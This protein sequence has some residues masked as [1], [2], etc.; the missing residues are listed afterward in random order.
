MKESPEWPLHLIPSVIEFNN[1]Q[2]K[3][4]EILS[5]RL[6]YRDYLVSTNI[7]DLPEPD[8]RKRA[9]T[10]RQVEEDIDII[11]G[12]IITTRSLLDLAYKSV[13]FDVEKLRELEELQRENFYLTV[14]LNATGIEVRRL[15]NIL[16]YRYNDYDY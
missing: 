11:S 4:E 9:V 15:R 16:N 3:I 13:S 1:L 2:L 5:R 14:R 10:I 6:S 7:I 12:L 8:A